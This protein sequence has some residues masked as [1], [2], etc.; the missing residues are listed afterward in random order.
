MAAK[1]LANV[2]TEN[3]SACQAMSLMQKQKSRNLVIIEYV[4]VAIMDLASEQRGL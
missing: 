4:A 2:H 3:S 1:S